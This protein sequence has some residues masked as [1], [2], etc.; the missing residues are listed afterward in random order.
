MVCFKGGHS[1]PARFCFFFFSSPLWSRQTGRGHYV[2]RTIL[3]FKF[4]VDLSFEVD[5]CGLG[6]MSEQLFNGLP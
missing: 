2:L 3:I 4:M 6:E 5:I 1:W